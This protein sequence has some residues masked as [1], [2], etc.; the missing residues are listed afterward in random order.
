MAPNHSNSHSPPFHLRHILRPVFAPPSSTPVSGPSKNPVVRSVDGYNSFL[1][2]GSN[3]GRVKG[4]DLR[5]SPSPEPDQSAPTGRLTPQSSALKSPI[6]SLGSRTSS[7]KPT[8]PDADLVVGGLE[9]CCFQ[10]THLFPPSETARSKAIERLLLVPPIS[11]AV[12]LSEGSV[13]FHSILDLEPY[14]QPSFPIIRGVSAL[15]LDEDTFDYPSPSN[16]PFEVTMCVIKK[17]TIHIFRLRESGVQQIFELPFASAA[18]NGLLRRSV[19]LLS[20]VEQYY[21]VSLNHSADLIPLLPI[22]QSS[23]L[24]SDDGSYPSPQHRP[25]MS[26]IPH[27]DEFLIASHTGSTC[28]GVFVS[29]SGDPSRGTL[30]WPSNP[31]SVFVDATHVLALLFNGTIEVHALESQE[32]I[33]VITLSPGLDARMLSPA[34]FSLAVPGQ[35][36]LGR[37]QPLKICLF[38]PDHASAPPDSPRTPPMNRSAGSRSIDR[39]RPLA[40]QSAV[41]LVGR[42]SVHALCTKSMLTEVECL[43]ASNRWDDALHFTESAVAAG[44]EGTRSNHPNARSEPAT[45]VRYIYQ[46][47]ALRYVLETR[48]EEAGE[49]WFKGQGDPRALIRL[50]PHLRANV[51]AYDDELELYEGL[52]PLIR[53]VRSA[54]ELIMANLVRNYSPHLKP[55][56]ERAPSAVD[57]KAHLLYKARSMV[58]SYL[59]RWKRDRLLKGGA[60][61]GAGDRYLD[62]IVDTALVELLAEECVGV[63]DRDEARRELAKLLHRPNACV[64]AEVEAVLEKNEC[65]G[66]LAELFLRSNELGK[67]LK[68]WSRLHDR[69]WTDPSFD[70]PLERMASLLQKIDQPHL[71]SQYAIWLANHD[72]TLSLRVLV[73]SVVAESLDVRATLAELQK[74]NPS[75]AQRYL[76]HLVL[77]PLV[78]RRKKRQSSPLDLAGLRTSLILG[79]LTSLKSALSPVTTAEGRAEVSVVGRLFRTLVEQYVGEDGQ[80]ADRP[81]F[82]EH[83]LRAQAEMDSEPLMTR[84]KLILCLDQ[85]SVNGEGY[86]VS[87]VRKALEEMGGRPETMAYERAIVYSKLGL[88]RLALSLLA[89]TLRDLPSSERYCLRPGAF[90]SLAQ[91]RAILDRAGSGTGLVPPPTMV[92]SREVSSG[93]LLVILLE[94]TVG[95]ASPI[96]LGSLLARH[97]PTLVLAH[98]T[99]PVLDAKWPLDALGPHL[100][101][102]L[103]QTAH[104]RHEAKL[105]KAVAAG[106][107][108]KVA[109]RAAQGDLKRKD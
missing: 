67:V 46:K 87:G 104:L 31:R 60:N 88:H 50:F 73:E 72:W 91:V 23:S 108:F 44:L 109:E 15:T 86:D 12:I 54:D 79:Y 102:S 100:T 103:R 58:L 71:V 13:T 18:F 70:D 57:L 83:L 43:M 89:V 24:P 40:S 48:F 36:F 5:P 7:P 27:S 51:I 94:L 90:L 35:S 19:L 6:S 101:R 78:T 4:F 29:S 99:L 20:D 33:Q 26:A 8:K 68:T 47:I 75:A 77:R 85:V 52:E 30:E 14:P 59:R 84:L 61:A 34:K 49:L 66:L 81:P 16:A 64:Q 25:S 21:L 82:V 17:K 106:Q 76:E 10:D 55:D 45:Q 69:Q 95:Y 62:A 38:S 65:Y 11:M 63:G 37:L 1:W 2:I 28:L 56:I 74:V 105:L 80:E 9:A 32:L 93:E 98:R 42:D 22:S 97:T 107:E 3:E 53:D 39:H 96:V 92:E 41:L